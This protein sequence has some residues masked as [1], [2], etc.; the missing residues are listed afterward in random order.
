MRRV[1]PL[2]ILVWVVIAVAIIWIRSRPSAPENVAPDAQTAP[3]AA[4][5]VARTNPASLDRSAD[6][7]GGRR[8]RARTNQ[9]P[10][11]TDRV[12]TAAKPDVRP[13]P[14]DLAGGSNR[15]AG[16]QSSD[17]S[18]DY[19]ELVSEAYRAGA[20]AQ[21][22]NAVVN[23]GQDTTLGAESEETTESLPAEAEPT[24]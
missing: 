10:R 24:Q 1:N 14:S 7:A 16:T 5:P 17:E 6:P 11:S 4:Q 20:A 13:T 9:P 2:A 15:S 12:R 21:Q 18:T 19:G 23:A 22:T 8:A 3:P